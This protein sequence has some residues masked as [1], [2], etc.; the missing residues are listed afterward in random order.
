MKADQKLNLLK[1]VIPIILTEMRLTIHRL[2]TFLVLSWTLAG[3]TLPAASAPEATPAV[4]A[5]PSPLGSQANPIVLAIRPGSG[6]EAVQATQRIAAEL[7]KL[8]G[9]TVTAGEVESTLYL[10]DSLGEGSVHI[11]VLSPFAYLS[12][13]E[14]GYANAAF[15]G[16]LNGQDKFGAQF[17]VNAQTAGLS[18]YKVYFDEGTQANRV[19]AAAALTQFQGARPCWSNSYSAAGYV[20]PLGMLKLQNIVVKDGAFLQGDEAVVKTIYQDTKGMLCDFGVTI[21]DSRAG[22]LAE[23][24]DVNDKVLV[25]WRTDALIPVD[26]IAYSASL[27]EDLRFRLSAALAVIS[28]Q[29]PF[30]VKAA[31]GVDALVL[32]DDSF[33]TDLRTYLPLSGLGLE[34]LIR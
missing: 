33:Y 8:S 10:I 15:A 5:T 27:P 21:S 31:F 17:I 22:L 16:T 18:G 23:L 30:D 25:V 2:L 7:S 19:D 4:T 11:A 34:N 1:C 24:P 29:I 26:G 12:A 3:C 20:F 13:R 6:P 28:V 32:T 9:L 14:K